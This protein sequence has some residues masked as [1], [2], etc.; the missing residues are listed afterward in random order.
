MALRVPILKV[1]DVTT[2]EWAWPVSVRC[3]FPRC[4]PET[5]LPFFP[6]RQLITVHVSVPGFMSHQLHEPLR[7][8]PLNFE[9]HRALE[10]AQP[11]VHQK[12][13]NENRRDA[14]WNEPFIADMAGW[15]KHQAFCR[16]LVVQ[17]SDQRLQRRTLEPQSE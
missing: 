9:H 12:E 8:P 11:V 5:I 4:L 16:K 7:R 10:R 17:L 1:N 15:L 13:W 14:D 2:A 3:F 6:T